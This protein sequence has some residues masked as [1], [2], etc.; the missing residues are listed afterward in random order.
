MLSLKKETVTINSSQDGKPIGAY[1]SRPISSSEGPAIILIHEWWGLVPHIKDV[2]DRY[3]SEGYVVI[4]P[5]LYSG[6][7][8]SNPEEAAKLSS[9]VSTDSSKS[10]LD[11][12]V[13]YLSGK[14]FVDSSRIGITGFCFGGTHSFNYV[15]ESNK[16]SAGVLFYASQPVE[17]EEKLGKLTGPLLIFYGEQ[18]YRVKPEQ[19]RLIEAALRKLGKNAEL[20][21]YPECGHGF[22]NDQNK[23]R[24]RLEEAKD[25]WGRTLT[26]FGKYLGRPH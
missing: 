25:A 12:I 10:M 18:D 4:A 2:A 9:S 15:C 17:S 26:F 13:D 14:D 21:I 23:Q 20:V 24:Y 3:A 5:D 6:A 22:F 11:S 16:I 1:L 7:V 8:A 19:A